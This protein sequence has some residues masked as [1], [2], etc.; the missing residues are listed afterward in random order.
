MNITGKAFQCNNMP[1]ALNTSDEIMLGKLICYKSTH[2]I[3]QQNIPKKIKIQL[4]KF[5]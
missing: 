1:E 5:N 3:T 4:K 2:F